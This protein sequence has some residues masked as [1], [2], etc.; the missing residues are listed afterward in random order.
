MSRFLPHG[1]ILLLL[2]CPA[3]IAQRDLTDLPDPDPKAELASFQVLDGFEVNLWASEPDVF[4][5]IQ[6]NW[7]TEGRLWV[8]CSSLYPQIAPG[9]EAND[10]IIVLEDTDRDGTADSSTVFADGLL[11]PTGILPGDGGCY[12]ANSTE[13]LHLSDTDGDGKA[14][15]R[16]V[17]LSGFGTEDTHHMIH[18]F[19]WG[20]DGLFY[21]NQSVY[22]HSHVETP[23]GPRRLGGGGIWQY[24]PENGRL[25]VFARGF[26]NPWGHHYDRFGQNFATDG[27]GF[28]GVAHVVPGASYTA[29]SNP[30][31]FLH[32][33]NPGSPKYC[34]A[35]IASGRHLPEEV[36]GNLVT[37]DFRAN[38][39][40]RFA[41]EPDGSSFVSRE[42]TPLIRSSHVGFRPID[43][44]MGPDGAIYVA[45]WYNPIIQ[46]GE[47]DFRDDRRDHQ[48]GRIWRITA[49][50]RLLV[51]RPNLTDAP[52]PALL[53]S[54]TA[55]EGWTREAA[56][57]V[58]KERGPEAV[59]PALIQWTAALDPTDGEAHLEALWL[60]Q[61]LDQADPTL[62][63]SMLGA[64]DPNLRAAAVRVAGAWHDRLSDPVATLAPLVV[65]D[66][67]RVRLEAVRALALVPDP[68]AAEVALRALA[69]PVDST[70]DYALYLTAVETAPRWLP[71]VVEGKADLGGPEPLAFALLAVGSSEVMDPLMRLV[72]SGELPERFEPD[73][74]ALIGRL[75]QPDDLRRVFEASL[76]PAAPVDRRARLLDALA[77]AA[78][79]RSVR[80]SGAL[81]AVAD[82]IANDN[83]PAA[84][85]A[86]AARAAGAWTLDPGASG[87]IGLATG[88]DAPFEARRSALLALAESG[89]DEARRLVA[90]LAASASP[91]AVRTGAIEALA[92]FDLNAAAAQAVASLSDAE[93]GA[94]PSG[95]VAALANRRG[96]P[97][98]LIAALDGASLPPDAAKL[99][100]R[101]ARSVRQ[102]DSSLADALNRAGGLDAAPKPATPEDVA[103]LVADL[104]TQGDANR[105]ERIYRREEMQCIKCHAIAGAGGKVGPGLE[106][107]GASAPD[108]YLVESLLL[109]NTAI[110]EGYHA[111]VVATDDG[112]IL[113]GIP[114]RETADQLVLRDAEG[115]EIAIPA[116]SIEERALGGS[117]MPNGLVDPL[118]RAELLDLA[119]FLSAMGEPGPFAIGTEVVARSWEVVVPDGPSG[120]AIRRTGLEEAVANNDP[121]F[122][123]QTVT[124]RVSGSLPIDELPSLTPYHQAPPLTIARLWFDTSAEGPVRLRL[125]SAEG[126]L[127][128]LDGSPLDPSE[129]MEPTVSAGRHWLSVVIDRSARSEE[130]IRV[131]FEDVPGSPARAQPV[132]GMGN[133]S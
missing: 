122:S 83:A 11:I 133:G 80:P 81:D 123:W 87:L 89:N 54:L 96:G 74:L 6:M 102:D 78:R 31:R 40:V 13:I 9:Q 129:V 39:V 86:A 127:V 5:P 23:F 108:D 46:H 106:S 116:S 58:L 117:L 56:R 68:N 84:V 64:D 45:D 8:A 124:T 12:V 53:D 72:R 118:T 63:A 28:E 29:I 61:A 71:S 7:D 59:L 109:P 103:S 10:Q 26:V 125:D 65:D 24:R 22:I 85:R 67:P 57:Q 113:N 130:G 92:S 73:A 48:R 14:D 2:I 44:L 17:V 34:G 110:K 131:S 94:N 49:K 16:R 101:A 120:E 114:I 41:L 30:E 27:A 75:G 21:F 32:G 18:T 132:T 77:G 66:H 98:A 4:K 33:L 100:A 111:I 38:R 50:D 104:R 15:T 79:E 1:L 97:E 42:Q 128:W 55:P 126:L 35:V 93:A 62:L 47:V 76:D 37:N 43:V 115:A 69:L 52:V 88:A 90:E 51:E 19:R 99:A 119:A 20:F 60:H 25:E 3:A 112:R 107:I 82:L 105:G 121:R 36:A 91:A 95:L 70:L